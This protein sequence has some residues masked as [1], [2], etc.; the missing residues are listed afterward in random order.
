MLLGGV[1]KATGNASPVAGA[2]Q[3]P[4][5]GRRH[6]AVG[7]ALWRSLPLQS[8]TFRSTP[9]TL[10]RG[11][12]GMQM[13]RAD[14]LERYLATIYEA[15]WKEGA[16]LGDP[17]VLATTL[18]AAASMP[19]PSRRWSAIRRSRPGSSRRPKK[20]WHAAC[21]AR[22]TFFVGDEMFF[23][24]DRL[25]FVA[26]ALASA[27][28]V[29]APLPRAAAGRPARARSGR[30]RLFPQQPVEGLDVERLDHERV[31]AGRERV[32]AILRRAVAG[33]RDRG[34]APAAAPRRARAAPL[35]SR[36]CRAGRCRRSRPRAPRRGWRRRPPRRRRRR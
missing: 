18:A 28:R 22:P 15:M 29:V 33:D 16:N 26:E 24:Q 1:F 14:D 23:G 2:G 32:L 13:R 31:E 35:R 36:R 8:R 10:M 34:G 4:L 17:V 7:A 19:M 30:R 9:L 12:A 21:S 27:A 20:R 25:D 3:G 5:D 11:A 6:R